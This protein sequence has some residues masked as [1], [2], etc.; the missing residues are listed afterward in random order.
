[1]REVLPDTDGEGV[2]VTLK[3]CT[4]ERLAVT[5]A[6]GEVLVEREGAADLEIDTVG[7]PLL[8]PLGEGEELPRKTVTVQEVDTLSTG[9]PDGSAVAVKE[10]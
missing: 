2:F 6:L 1:M 8:E 7:V 9:V 4:G 10:D 5:E 3:V